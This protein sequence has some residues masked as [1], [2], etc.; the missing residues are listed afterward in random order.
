MTV[1]E[2]YVSEI[3]K[4]ISKATAENAFSLIYEELYDLQK[5]FIE[6]QLSDTKVEYEEEVELL[7]IF[8]KANSLL[9]AIA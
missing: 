1:K 2:K 6:N 8:K 4:I 9:H 7:D 5:Q 3:I